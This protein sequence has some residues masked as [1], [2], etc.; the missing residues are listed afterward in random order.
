MRIQLKL[1]SQNFK[2]GFS[3]FSS[4]TYKCILLILC[5][6]ILIWIFPSLRNKNEVINN[7]HV[8]KWNEY[9]KEV[10]RSYLNLKNQ[11]SVGDSGVDSIAN[12][13]ENPSAKT[14][15]NTSKISLNHV[16]GGVVSHHV[17]TMIPQLVRFYFDLKM[18]QNVKKFIVIGPDHVNAG[19]SYITTSSASFITSYAELKPIND[20]STKMQDQGLATIEEL[21]F[22]DEHS[23]GS[24]FLV[25]SKIF[26]EA[27]V[28]PI[29]LR[30][31][32]PKEKAIELGRFLARNLDEDTVV[33]AS[34]DFSHYLPH[35]QAKNIDEIS[36]QVLKT[37]DQKSV[38]LITADSNRSMN[39]FIEAMLSKGAKLTDKV[40]VLN[41]ND[42]MQ[43]SD[44]TTGYVFG[45]WGK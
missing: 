35:A 26:P 8:S 31:N 23:I 34:V 4:L 20:L 36:G 19:S 21:P 1:N 18:H 38:S 27:K 41:T 24:Q 28:T 3:D 29:I 33:I 45:Y 37:L 32:T 6:A 11:Y 14:S 39:T 22:A 30:S 40:Q 5:I 13:G 42:V 16:Y 7:Y 9:S 25:I 10:D 2:S 12:T 43:N 44:Y 17:P 15:V